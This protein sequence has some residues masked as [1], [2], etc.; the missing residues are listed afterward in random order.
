MVGAAAAVRRAGQTG[1]ATCIRLEAE[2]TSYCAAR[3]GDDFIV[4]AGWPE[5][6]RSARSKTCPAKVRRQAVSGHDQVRQRGAGEL[7]R[8]GVA[9]EVSQVWPERHRS[10]RAIAAF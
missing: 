6:C 4:H 3:D 5:P 1:R 10:I 8:A 7:A 9:V 2:N